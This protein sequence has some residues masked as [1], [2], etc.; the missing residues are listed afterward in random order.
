MIEMVLYRILQLLV[1]VRFLYPHFNAPLS[2]M[3]GMSGRQWKQAGN[4]LSP[5]EMGG[6]DSFLYQAWL[7][8]VRFST[9]DIAWLVHTTSG[10]LCALMPLAWYLCARQ[11]LPRKWALGVAIAIAVTPSFVTIYAYF[12]SE[13]LLLPLIGLACWQTVACFQNP[14]S[15]RFMLAGLFWMLAAYTRV[16][17]LPPAL[18]CIG[19]LW[20]ACGWRW[21]PLVVIMLG[22]IAV[23]V[24]SALHSHEAVNIYAPFGVPELNKILARSH[25]K[26]VTYYFDGKKQ[27]F[28]SPAASTYPLEPFSSWHMTNLTY[29]IYVRLQ[30]KQGS[31]MWDKALRDY[32]LNAERVI[33][34]L[35]YN[36]IFI[37]FGP[38]WPEVWPDSWSSGGQR[39]Y[40]EDRINYWARWMWAPLILY[41]FIGAARYRGSDASNAFIILT[42][43]IVI[44]LSLQMTAVLEGRYRKPVEPMLIVAAALIAHD[45]YQRRQERCHEHS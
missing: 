33:R 42:L 1:C 14:S 7:A 19:V 35:S 23:G 39:I 4:F 8:L 31:Q 16:V 15:R 28:R 9:Q 2:H 11:L 32:P 22:F 27:W 36:T 40:W 34:Q 18:G 12:S 13:T 24:P 41:A 21:R 30:K 25:T 3:V 6:I 43:A 45:R 10:V 37:L 29:P 17:A 26:R 5:T 38:S 44:M 20:W